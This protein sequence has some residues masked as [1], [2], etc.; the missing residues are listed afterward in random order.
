MLGIKR[1]VG[2]VDLKNLVGSPNILM[3]K[4]TGCQKMKLFLP[5]F[6]EMYT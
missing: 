5:F 1:V 2:E 6:M 3:I 4:M